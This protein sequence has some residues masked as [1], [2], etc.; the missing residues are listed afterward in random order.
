MEG[1]ALSLL[2]LAVPAAHRIDGR[3]MQRLPAPAKPAA[4]PMQSESKPDERK[5]PMNTTNTLLSS[6]L[7][8]LL[9][10]P[11]AFATNET[12]TPTKRAYKKAIMWGTVGVK[13]SVLEKMK[14]TFNTFLFNIFGLK[15]DSADAADDGTIDGLMG[16]ILDIRSQ[17]R[18][19]KDWGTSDK[20]RDALAAV[21]IQVKD[22]KDGASWSK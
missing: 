22:G 20:I 4:L 7:V 9:A 19:Q 16:L 8:A 12:P 11:L 17:A 1:A 10:A 15:D 21:G 6:V 3:L 5:I 13:G 18:E 2:N 14:A